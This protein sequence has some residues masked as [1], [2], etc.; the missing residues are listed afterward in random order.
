MKQPLPRD[1]LDGLLDNPSGLDARERLERRKRY[2]ANVI[3][4]SAR[5]GIWSVLADTLRDPMLWFLVGTAVV[6]LMVGELTEALVLL[7]ALVPFLGMDAF[8][9]HRT[10]VST[11]TLRSQL[12]SVARVRIGGQV[13]EVPSEEVVPGDLL[14]VRSGEPFPA[15]GVIVAAENLQVDESVLSGEAYPV[16]KARFADQKVAQA[17][18][19][20]RDNVWAFAGTRVLTGT[21]RLRVAYTGPETLYGEIVRTAVAGTQGRTPLQHAVAHLVKVLLWIALAICGLLAMTRLWQGH[22][23]LDAVLSAVTLAVA[24]LPEEFPVVLTFFLGLGVF[25]LARRD[26]LVRRAVAV[27]NISRTT[28]ICCDKTGTLT[29][30]RLILAHW[31]PAEQVEESGLL[32]TAARA[33]RADSGDPMDEAIL[34]VAGRLPEVAV[35]ASFPFTEQRK[36]ETSLILQGSK[37]WAAVKGAP[38]TVLAMC[39]ESEAG[40]RYWLEKV[41]ELADSGHKV[42]ACAQQE[43]A[44]G[45]ES[46]AEPESGFRFAGL[47]A[48]E[49]PVREG[50]VEALASCEASGVRVIMVTGDHAGTAAA[51]ARQIGLG[52]GKP[53]V[54][55]GEEFL[56]R[57]A[58]G[59][60]L[61]LDQV[62]VVAR[63]VPSVK[64]ELVQALQRRGEIVAV[65]GDGVNDVPALKAADIGIAMGERGT[66]SAREVSA[67]VLMDDNF[68]TIVRAMEEGW[69]LFRNLR[70]SFQYLLMIHIPLVLT[71]S[72]IPLLGFPVL[73]LP[74]HIVWLELIIHPTAMLVFQNLP[75]HSRLPRTPPGKRV[76]LLSRTDTF[77]VLL[78]G[79]LTTGLVYW[80][81]LRSLSE[82]Q[83]VEHARS[84]ALAAL[85]VAGAVITASL[86]R[87][88]G[89]VAVVITAGG[90]LSALVLIQMP[91]TAQW[92]H[93]NPLHLEDWLRAVLTGALVAIPFV[94]RALRPG[95][96]SAVSS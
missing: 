22:G 89:K 21:A 6:F 82:L 61:V 47:L 95:R 1:R 9:H 69:Q 32:E 62:D 68:R 33:S 44:D 63:A 4:E 78:V 31:Y 39:T 80:S 67:I 13:T 81:Y 28:C 11:A 96:T 25:R 30:G 43:L 3:V 10:Q 83:D 58:T 45:T 26:A 94:F 74:I 17:D 50:V 48:F 75:E 56:D 29:E 2:G 77:Q 72:L 70:L 86:S 55:T 53:R 15:D 90:V 57:L 20:P 64:L 91:W 71:A 36:R 60:D 46:T 52:T 8:L 38:E 18:E 40:H 66:R 34:A 85:I 24:A 16:R 5:H 92:L 12:A 49:D 88:K 41:G 42:I 73:Y 93:L 35:A 37:L 14:E 65:T 19:K 23:W 27:E 76:R 51:V 79:F 87:L 7:V 84:M 59:E 54:L